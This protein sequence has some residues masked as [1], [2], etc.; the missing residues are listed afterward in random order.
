MAIYTG[1]MRQHSLQKK[2]AERLAKET[3]KQE[4]KAKKRKGWSGLLGKVAGTGIGALAAGA[5]GVATGGLAMPL[6]MAAGQFA[7]R[8]LAHE[9]TGAMGMGA[10]SSKI[11]S[12]SKYGYGT[13]EAK[14]LREGLEQQ[15]AV[16]PMKE[17]G[18]FGKDLLS[19]YT[20]AGV[21]GG[22]SGA[23]KAL[24]SGDK[25]SIAQ[26]L[27]GQKDW[28]GSMAS[29]EIGGWQGAMGAIGLG[30]PE[31]VYS[32]LHQP[33]VVPSVEDDL[34]AQQM[35]QEPYVF[36]SEYE[37]EIG[38]SVEEPYIFGSENTPFVFGQGEEGGQV[39]TKDQLIA[40][41][42]AS[43]MRQPKAHDDTPL[44]EIHSS[45]DNISLKETQP[46]IAEYFNSEGKTLGGNNTQSLSQ[47]LGR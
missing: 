14:T 42:M 45:Y 25:G 18:G 3:A 6:I 13:K 30:Q 16:D 23:G 24:L 9:A 15:M 40:L 31:D 7:G 17:R 10:D 21:S 20:S 11:K 32:P 39:P 22:L 29:K 44:E 33:D 19:A 26:A 1:T 34:L 8:K 35:N 37:P 12:Q 43:K 38:Q 2:E 5:L 36:G 4:A 47:M 41:L 28:A 46:T 27:T